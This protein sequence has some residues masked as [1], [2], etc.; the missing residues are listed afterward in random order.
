MF[1]I[2]GQPAGPFNE[3]KLRYI[4]QQ[5]SVNIY[6]RMYALLHFNENSIK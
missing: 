1:K 3:Q 4:R 2:V 5:K 6:W